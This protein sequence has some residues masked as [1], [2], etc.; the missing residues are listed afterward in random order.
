MEQV[1]DTGKIDLS[2][3][4]VLAY[5]PHTEDLEQAK[6]HIDE[7]GMCIVSNVLCAQEVA[8]IDQRLKEQAAGEAAG[9]LGTIVRGDEGFGIRAAR[10]AKVSRLVWNLVNKGECFLPLVDH[11]KTLPLIQ[12]ILGERIL[13]GSIGAHMNGSGNE[14]MPLHQDQW[15]LI[16]QRLP[17]AAW[18]N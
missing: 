11:P 18:A 9:N 10:E 14:M 16:P 2:R 15:P 17:F 13:L 12:H 8:T 7:Y 4:T 3:L 5:P 6:A 1:K